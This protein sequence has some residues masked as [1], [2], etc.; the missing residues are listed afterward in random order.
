MHNFACTLRRVTTES[1]PMDA[2]RAEVKRRRENLRLTTG[3]AGP[4]AGITGQWW[5]NLED[6]YQVK[7]GGIRIP[8]RITRKRLIRI[9][10]ALRWDVNDALAMS[11]GEPLGNVEAVQSM[12]SDELICVVDALP[13][14]QQR[15]LLLLAKSMADPATPIPGA[16][17]PGSA[18]I[19]NVP[20]EEPVV[21]SNDHNGND[22]DGDSSLP[23]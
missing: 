5:R 10:R 8:A 20:H 7:S 14:P 22:R 11:R 13:V 4:L 6:G 23:S 9:A 3:E 1:D 15:L 17:Q 2:V 21:E 12:I 19:D 16:V 18:T